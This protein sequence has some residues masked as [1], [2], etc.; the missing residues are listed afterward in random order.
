LIGQWRC[1]KL[2][3]SSAVMAEREAELAI[4][5][6]RCRDLIAGCRRRCDGSGRPSPDWGVGVMVPGTEHG[7]E[8]DRKDAK[9]RDRSARVP[10]SS[11]DP[12]TS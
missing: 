4:L 9:K 7:L 2:D 1:E 5:V 10:P 3:R 11:P 6:R 8:E 12:N